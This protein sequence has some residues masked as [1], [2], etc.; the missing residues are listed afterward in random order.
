MATFRSDD[1]RLHLGVFPCLVVRATVGFGV[2]AILIGRYVPEPG[3]DP[4]IRLRSPASPRYHQLRGYWVSEFQHPPRLLDA[5]TGEVRPLSL[6]GAESLDFLICSP[7][8]DGHGQFRLVGRWHGRSGV[9]ANT[10]TRSVGLACCTF[11][12][13]K[14]LDRVEL[15]AVPMGNPCW[16]PDGSGRVLYAAGSGQLYQCSFPG[17]GDE[18]RGPVPPAMPRPIRWRAEPPGR[19]VQWI[20]DLHWPNLRTWENRILVSLSYIERDSVSPATR[21]RL[22][23]LDLGGDGTEIVAA[24]RLIPSAETDLSAGR[25]L[26]RLPTVGPM[27]Q[28]TAML[29]YLARDRSRRT[30]DLWV[31]P[32]ASSRVDGRSK[33]VMLAGRK[34][35]EGC[36]AMAPAFSDDGRWVYVMRHPGG[37]EPRLERFQVATTRDLPEAVGE[38]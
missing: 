16:Y 5:K 15:D 26:E 8:Q 12:E 21:L 23:W 6:S 10:V 3:S 36:Y 29:A 2:A 19:G 34:L 33:A 28:G 27:R 24:G 25:D 7:W 38:E 37:P 17:Q 31:T 4:P 14:I 11:P 32:I 20:Q 18:S 30:W 1:M 35:A 9:G 22:W 13:G